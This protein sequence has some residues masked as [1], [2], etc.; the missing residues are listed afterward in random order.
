MQSKTAEAIQA[1]PSLSRAIRAAALAYATSRLI[2]FVTMMV[3]S[4]IATHWTPE[5]DQDTN[6]RLLTQDSIEHLKSR[7]LANDASWYLSISTDGY[8][9][10]QFDASRA[11]N[12]AFFPLFPWLW[13]SL[14]SLGADAAWS[15]FF[16]SNILFFLGLTQLH[17]WVQTIRGAD[18]ADRAVLVIAIFPTAYFFSLP[19]SE[20][21]FL[22]LASSSLLSLQQG[23]LSRASLFNALLSASRPTGVFYSAVLWWENRGGHLLP[24]I[25]IWLLAAAGMIG[26]L[27]FMSVLHANTGNALAFVDIQAAWGR[28]G[29]SFTKHFRRWV[30]DPLL[31]AEPWNLRWLNNS[32][33]LLGLAA[34]AWLWRQKMRGLAILSFLCIFMPW[35]TG[36][37]VSMG[38]YLL[39]IPP[40]FLAFACWLENPRVFQAWIAISSALLTGLCLYFTLGL[41]LAGA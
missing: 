14:L 39:T 26:I 10:R 35:S 22:L 23:R 40:L 3:A 32:A 29:G 17:R 41:S 11:A 2:V 16:L 9:Q 33:L 36:T 12:W 13:Q 20:S 34:S 15:G 30:M 7:I 21:L 19:W 28:D 5:N 6:I 25:R 27:V 38:R 18:V 4:A 1:T 31:L 37:L 24:P 8:E